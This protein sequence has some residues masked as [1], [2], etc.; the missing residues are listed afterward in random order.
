MDNDDSIY[1]MRK[2]INKEKLKAKLIELRNKESENA[3]AAL[4]TRQSFLPFEYARNNF[5]LL[6]QEIELGNF[7]DN[8]NQ[9][10][11]KE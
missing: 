11:C 3:L 5:I 1:V 10:Q 2:M 7:D 4:N 9:L 6:L 8:E